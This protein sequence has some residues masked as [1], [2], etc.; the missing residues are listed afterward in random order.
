M[1]MSLPEDAA[2]PGFAANTGP[3]LKN[4]QLLLESDQDLA[5]MVEVRCPPAQKTQSKGR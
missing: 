2:Q 1:R 3:D 4:G 5:R